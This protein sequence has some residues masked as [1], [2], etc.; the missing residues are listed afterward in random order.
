MRKALHGGTVTGDVKERYEKVVAK[1]PPHR[2]GKHVAALAARVAKR[3]E[4]GGERGGKRGAEHGA[5]AAIQPMETMLKEMH[6]HL[7]GST[8]QP[9]VE[10]CAS[11]VRQLN[12]GAQDFYTHFPWKR[13]L[14]MSVL[15][16][17]LRRMQAEQAGSASRSMRALADG[18]APP[19]DADATAAEAPVLA[20]ADTHAPWKGVDVD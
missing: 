18:P 10:R 2:K 19:A 9:S 17:G 15:W 14:Y 3:A 5:R 6:N 1:H 13:H 7:L 11:A 20:A 4:E 16:E 12:L 8:S